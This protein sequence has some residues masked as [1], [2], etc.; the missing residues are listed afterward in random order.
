MTSGYLRL[1]AVL[2]V[3]LLSSVGLSRA[4][5]LL[6]EGQLPPVDLIQELKSNPLRPEEDFRIT[7]LV[8][9]A[10][11]SA[12][13]V[14]VRSTLPPHFHKHTREVVYFLQGEGVF[15]LEAESIPI[16]DGAVLLIQPGQVHTFTNQGPTPAVFFVVTSPRFD[17][18]DRIMIQGEHGTFR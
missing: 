4:A 14:Q 1:L 13:L 11:Q 12:L 7:R 16:R 5:A 15:L 17:E 9:N 6:P 3:C 18:R 2:G 8:E 10:D